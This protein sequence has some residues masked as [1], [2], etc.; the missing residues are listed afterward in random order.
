MSQVLTSTSEEST[1]VSSDSPKE[2]AEAFFEF[3]SGLERKMVKRLSKHFEEDGSRMFKGVR[4][5]MP[6]IQQTIQWDV[7]MQSIV[8][9]LQSNQER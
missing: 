2:F 1:E 8:H 4:L 5:A 7:N 6:L 3:F 9:T